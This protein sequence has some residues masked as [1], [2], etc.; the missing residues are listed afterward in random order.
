MLRIYPIALDWLKAVRPLIAQIAR[1][2][3]D[4]AKQLRRSSSSVI[5]NLGEGMY[6][7]GGRRT[8]A[9]GVA[10]REMG[11]SYSALQAAQCT[12]TSQRSSRPLKRSVEEFSARS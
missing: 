6:S 2:D 9:Y 12:G 1:Y 4:L 11:E 5:L 3:G 10:L 7:L 8:N